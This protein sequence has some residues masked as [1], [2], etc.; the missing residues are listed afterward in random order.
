MLLQL[1]L[2]V[3]F[4]GGCAALFYFSF[5]RYRNA[6][7]AIALGALAFAAFLGVSFVRPVVWTSKRTSHELSIAEHVSSDAH[8]A[9][10]LDQ[11]AL[12]NLPNITLP[13]EGNIDLVAIRHGNRVS[14]TRKPELYGDEQVEL[15]G[16]VADPVA[17]DPASGL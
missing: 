8:I 4:A 1:A 3:I 12:D 5:A 9:E 11:Q 16:W 17:G 10:P 15:R 6:R 13:A 7:L 14:E 2:A